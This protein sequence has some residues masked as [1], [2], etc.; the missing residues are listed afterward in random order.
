MCVLLAHSGF[1]LSD[2][3]RSHLSGISVSAQNLK[4]KLSLATAEANCLFSPGVLFHHVMRLRDAPAFWHMVE[5]EG[6]RFLNID[7]KSPVSHVCLK[8][9]TQLGSVDPCLAT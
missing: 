5:R 1:Y 3:I 7:G 2:L 4:P 9:A 6:K 8:N